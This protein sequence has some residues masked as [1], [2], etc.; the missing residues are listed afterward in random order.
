MTTA[1]IAGRPIAP[2]IPGKNGAPTI[3]PRGVAALPD[4]ARMLAPLQAGLDPSVI[5]VVG[6]PG[7]GKTSFAAG[8]SD[9][10][11][12]FTDRGGGR[13]LSKRIH[14][15]RVFPNAWD[16]VPGESP[17]IRVVN[18]EGIESEEPREYLIQ[19]V[20]ALLE[21][22][23]DRKAAVIDTLNNAQTLLYRYL[24]DLEKVNSIE[25]VGG[26][27]QKGFTRA[28]EHMAKLR[29][30]VWD[31]RDR[32][33][34][35][36]VLTSHQVNRKTKDPSGADYEAWALAV[37]PEIA[38]VW[39]G[40]ADTILYCEPAIAVVSSEASGSKDRPKMRTKVDFTGRTTAY[41]RPARGIQAKNRDMLPA[42]LELSWAVY[43]EE[44]E[45]G[46]QIQDDLQEFLHSLPR[47]AR[48]AQETYMAE[49]VWSR[50]AALLVLE[51]S[52]TNSTITNE[53]NGEQS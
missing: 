42:T 6:P 13:T 52:N 11:F 8:A 24:C 23:H 49:N 29:D 43:E 26:G 53:K 51:Q 20:R 4:M 15:H 21:K 27:F 50:E 9:P 14:K 48:A 25:D 37:H 31:L 36:V 28:A 7:T 10:V 38:D 19:W 17:T 30:L 1:P 41:T 2:P 40:A 32:R 22:P 34:M 12:L 5:V 47:A 3:A 33:R 44:S 45:K 46:K 18:E 39:M 16:V 35:N